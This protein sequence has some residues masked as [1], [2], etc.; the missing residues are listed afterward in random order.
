MTLMDKLIASLEKK[1][2]VIGIFLDFSKVFDTVDNSIL[3]RKLSHYGIRGN[4]LNWFESYLSGRTQYVTYNGVSSQYKSI[5]CGVP[6]GSILGP[7]LFLVYINDLCSLCKH[8]TPLLFADDTNLFCN[9]T[10]LQQMEKCIN[11]E[12]A[13]IS[14]WLKVN[15]LS[16]NVKKT[17][18]MLFTRSRNRPLKLNIVIDN[19]SIG[20]VR[21]TK[22]L[23]VFIDNKLNWKDHITYI[24]GKI[25]RGIGMII[26]A[27]NYLNQDG[28]L[29]LYHA[30][31]YPYFT[32]CNHI[33]GATYKSNLQRLV[34]L[35]NKIV[36]II[37]HVKPRADCKPLYYEVWM[38][39]L[40]IIC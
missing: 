1:E 26:K 8:T 28:L 22:F 23:G 27:R 18:Y 35:Q 24:S 37:S 34:I 19:E 38:Y 12:L 39:Q 6:Q 36:R 14:Q 9:G 40:F 15:T 25:S 20:E 31:I 7:Q 17:N 29:A 3:L 2:Y 16:L 32:Y 13:Q 30:F 11:D 4:A 5:S 21:R 10:D 33:W